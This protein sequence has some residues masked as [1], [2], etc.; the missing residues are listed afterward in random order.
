MQ[1]FDVS[2]EP[3]ER[4]HAPG[5]IS[6]AATAA[7]H[8]LEQELRDALAPWR[9]VPLLPAAVRTSQRAVSGIGGP[10]AMESSATWPDFPRTLHPYRREVRPHRSHRSLGSRASL[11]PELLLAT[12]RL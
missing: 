10:A 11:P 9:I 6:L 1:P 12:S 4:Q 7:P 2:A 5:V 3:G 8:Y